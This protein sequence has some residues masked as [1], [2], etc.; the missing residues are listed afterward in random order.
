[1]S[2]KQLSGIVIV[3]KEKGWTSFDVVA[4]LRRIFGLRRVGHSGTLDP[5]AEGVLPICLG[6]ATA[7]VRYMEP[8]DKRYTV[9]VAFGQATETQDPTGA[10]IGGNT[11]TAA[12]LARA[13][14]SGWPELRAAVAALPGEHQQVPPMYSAV[15]IKG[16]PL[17]K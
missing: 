2:V 13:Q 3:Y 5:F 14:C 15:K 6:R 1:M 16:E 7:A 11:P 12:E 17:Y 8:Y 4:V 9:T 10:V